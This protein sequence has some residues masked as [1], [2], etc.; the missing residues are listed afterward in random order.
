M[1]YLD[2]LKKEINVRY[3]NEKIKT[4]YIGGGTPSVLSINELMYLFEIIEILDL[5]LLEEFTF[6]CN[7][8]SLTKEKII[9]LKKNKVNRLSIGVQSFDLSKLNFLGIYR[10]NNNVYEILE[11]I[12]DIGFSNVNIDL[13]YAVPVES[14]ESLNKDIDI[15][16]SLNINHISCY[17]LMIEPNTKLFIKGVKQIDE[18]IDYD[19]YKMIEDRLTSNGYIH[20]E[21]SNYSKP[22]YESKHNL[23]YWNNEE[24][25]GFGL[26]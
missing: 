11:F 24:Y 1:P 9:L 17:S 25:Y 20:Y 3:K 5:S 21:I 4:L 2:S 12:K 23:V 18:E 22:G 15:F 19:M 8:E 6:E 7:V 13:I 14:L 16:L 10:Q 26:S